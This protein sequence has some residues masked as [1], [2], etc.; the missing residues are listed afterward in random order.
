MKSWWRLTRSRV[1]ERARGRARRESAS[2]HPHRGGLVRRPRRL[3]VPLAAYGALPVELLAA[4]TVLST[5]NYYPSRDG[6]VEVLD[7]AAK[8]TA[9]YEES[10]LPGAVLVKAFNNILAHHI[11]A[12]ARPA[13]AP[14]RSGLWAWS[15]V[16]AG[17]PGARE[18]WQRRAAG[19][20][21]AHGRG[22][23][24]RTRTAGLPHRRRVAGATSGRSG[25]PPLR[26]AGS[27]AS[28][29]YQVVATAFDASQV[30]P[31]RTKV[32]TVANRQRLREP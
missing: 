31:W 19:R 4:R 23:G 6:R 29:S 1:A 9:E 25:S 12:L 2:G 7:S 8:T 20:G 22:L 26:T 24:R 28:V 16:L 27:C 32:C 18:P 21:L 10:L 17:Q 5:C 15:P 30:W 3:A 11:P 13:G 14:D